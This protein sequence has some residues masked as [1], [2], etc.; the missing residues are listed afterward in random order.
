VF[1][2]LHEIVAAPARFG[3][4]N[5]TGPCIRLNVTAHAFCE[6]PGKFLFWDGIHPTVAG[7]RIL[8]KRANAAL[9]NALELAATP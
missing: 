9:R 2:I 1:G 5:V 3:L 6:R 7:H 8:A 4:T